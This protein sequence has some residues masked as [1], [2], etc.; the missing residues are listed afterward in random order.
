[1]AEPDPNSAS[2]SSNLGDA[3]IDR[4]LAEAESLT[5]EVAEATGVPARDADSVLSGEVPLADLSIGM[6]P[7]DPLAAAEAASQGVMSLEDLLSELGPAG[8]EALPRDS[9]RE[10]ASE[11]A[12]SPSIDAGL[13][14]PP[15]RAVERPNASRLADGAARR[16]DNL[17][18]ARGPRVEHAPGDSTGVDSGLRIEHMPEGRSQVDGLAA[19]GARAAVRS[20]AS[21]SAT[22]SD[23]KPAGRAVRLRFR[24]VID[25]I[26]KAAE[27][28]VR[29]GP[30]GVLRGLKWT[31]RSAG[32]GLVWV[33]A[34][35]P[36]GFL[37]WVDIPFR[38]IPRS[39]KTPIGILGLITLAMGGLAWAMPDLM[40]PKPVP[41]QT[42]EV[43]AEGDNG[44]GR[45]DAAKGH[46]SGGHGGGH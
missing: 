27:E 7:G 28:S 19:V 23:P 12:A 42:A 25:R 44:K 41:K 34:G 6:P 3:D 46:E 1:M 22:A 17:S 4:L 37:G 2:A 13:Q 16:A 35:L 8:L 24:A 5:R 39:I 40:R 15:D 32:R 26:K 29:A 43:E 31:I 45:G 10:A 9:A 36:I 20:R 30:R 33:F 21:E 14:E 38:R 18:A 11:A